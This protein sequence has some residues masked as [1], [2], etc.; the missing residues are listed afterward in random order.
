MGAVAETVG[1]FLRAI[2]SRP[3]PILEP[4]ST[5][6]AVYTSGLNLK[7]N[8]KPSFAF[9]VAA[10]DVRHGRAACDPRHGGGTRIMAAAVSCTRRCERAGP[11][12]VAL[13]RDGFAPSMA[14]LGA[15][16][17]INLFTNYFI[18]LWLPAILH[19]TATSPPWSIFG[20]TMYALGVILGG[21]LTAPVVD[22]IAV[23]RVLTGLLAL[24][25]VCLLSIGFLDPPFWLF[26]IIIGTG[27]CQAGLKTLSGQIYPPAIRSTGTGSALDAS[28]PSPVR[29]SVGRCYGSVGARR[30]FSSRPPSLHPR[31]RH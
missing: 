20:V 7:T 18:L 6:T 28:G 15:M 31:L 25:A 14:L 4:M 8:H 2:A 5:R 11:I 16:N 10:G 1:Y 21:L 19:A 22:R 3:W 29:F 12:P 17:L 24:G 30:L 9:F 23:E 26:S 27:G 13:L